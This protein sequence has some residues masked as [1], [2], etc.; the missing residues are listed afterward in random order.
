MTE[1]QIMWVAK[2]EARNLLAIAETNWLTVQRET[3]LQ[4]FEERIEKLL[5]SEVG[6]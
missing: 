2:E 3:L 4:M 5:R 1:E 6:R